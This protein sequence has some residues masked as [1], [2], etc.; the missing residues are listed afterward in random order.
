MDPKKK[1]QRA[2]GLYIPRLQSTKNDWGENVQTFS[3]TW[4][5]NATRSSFPSP[6]TRFCYAARRWLKP[7]ANFARP[8][9]LM[10]RTSRPFVMSLFVMAYFRLIGIHGYKH[11]SLLECLRKTTAN[12]A[13]MHLTLPGYWETCVEASCL[14][15]SGSRVVLSRVWFWITTSSACSRWSD[16]IIY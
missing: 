3:A 11:Y 14:E 16:T 7:S 5:N 12:R 13:F 15:G 10:W 8:D 2:E 6:P 1:F 4:Y 9:T